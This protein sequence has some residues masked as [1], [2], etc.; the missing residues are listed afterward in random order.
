MPKPEVVEVV[1]I[2]D[3]MGEPCWT[4]RFKCGCE[5]TCICGLDDFIAERLGND[6]KFAESWNYVWS[7][8]KRAWKDYEKSVDADG[9]MWH[10]A[11]RLGLMEFLD[12]ALNLIDL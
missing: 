4:E 11:D 5:G 7:R 12:A 8:F 9:T 10:D 2:S 1:D 6:P 3:G